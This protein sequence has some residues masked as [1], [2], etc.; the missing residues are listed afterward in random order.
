MTN[1][2]QCRN[3]RSRWTLQ[4]MRYIEAHYG[5]RPAKDIAA[6]L[7]RP[8]TSVC[9]MASSL[10]LTHP[11]RLWTE[12]EDAVLFATWAQG[13][14]REAV[15][16]RLPGRA[17]TAIRFR[18]VKLGLFRPGRWSTKELGILRTHYPEEGMAVTRRLQG[19]TLD[20]VKLKAREIG[21]KVAG[22][23]PGR[24]W[25]DEEWTILAAGVGSHGKNDEA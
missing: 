13:V 2:T 6:H 11:S 10:G 12:E 23:T 18:A 19:R 22:V 25:R 20:A 5:T 16:A 15:M 17:W 24:S 1:K 21:V 9:A 14:P 7:G 8:V 3:Y 4:E